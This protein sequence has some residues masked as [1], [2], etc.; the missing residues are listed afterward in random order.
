MKTIYKLAFALALL[1]VAT[2]CVEMIKQTAASAINNRGE[3]TIDLD[4]LDIDALNSVLVTD[5]GV[6]LHVAQGTSLDIQVKNPH[7]LPIAIEANG[8]TLL[9]KGISG[10]LKNQHADVYVKMPRVNS[11]AIRGSSDIIA[12]DL[13]TGDLMVIIDGSG[14]VDAADI[15]ARRAVFNIEGSGDIEAA[16]VTADDARLTVTGSGDIDVQS[17][18]APMLATKIEGSGEIGIKQGNIHDA[19]LLVSG[20]GE[21]DAR[22]NATGNVAATLDGSGEIHLTGNIPHLTRSHSGTGH[23]THNAAD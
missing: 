7:E 5:G 18:T 15:T 19:K 10:N 8:K 17:I 1:C 22:L 13:N 4:N 2:S 14:D 12:N 23:I 21:I 9:V 20:S 11:L 3:A 16:N 6:R